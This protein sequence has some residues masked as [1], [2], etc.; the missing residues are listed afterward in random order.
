MLNGKDLIFTFTHTLPANSNKRLFTELA[1]CIGVLCAGGSP[2]R[3]CPWCC[4][5]AH[6]GHRR[7]G[8]SA[9]ET[10]WI[11][12]HKALRNLFSPHLPWTGP[13]E[14]PV[15]R[16]GS[17][18]T[19]RETNSIQ[20]RNFAPGCIAV[21]GAP[22]W[23]LHTTSVV[24]NRQQLPG[25]QQNSSWQLCLRVFCE[26]SPCQGPVWCSE[27]TCCLPVCVQLL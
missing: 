9:P 16:H 19:Q 2:G 27:W 5:E 8:A 20:G 6:D 24:K 4:L 10:L 21:P 7:K 17:L 14:T 25:Q 18:T 26:V 23:Q 15:H 12:L 22:L 11:Q 3:C 1:V 13:L